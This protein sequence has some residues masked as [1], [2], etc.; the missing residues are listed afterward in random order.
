MKRYFQNLLTYAI[1]LGALIFL[2]TCM[3]LATTYIPQEAIQKHMQESAEILA[4]RPTTW[5]I[6]PGINSSKVHPY[7][8]MLTLNIAYHFGDDVRTYDS[9]S[10]FDQLQYSNSEK[11]KAVMWAKYT[12]PLK[13]RMNQLSFSSN[14]LIIGYLQT[15]N[16]FDIGTDQQVL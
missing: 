4:E 10:F 14:L 16:I 15:K 2:L 6:L 7:A 8:D 9:F 13:I 3:M 11:L 1:C 5:Q 12:V